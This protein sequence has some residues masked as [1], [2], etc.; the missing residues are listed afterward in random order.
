MAINPDDLLIFKKRA[1]IR[2]ETAAKV[3][4]TSNTQDSSELPVVIPTANSTSSVAAS[5]VVNPA[6]SNVIT[7]KKQRI[8]FFSRLRSKNINKEKEQKAEQKAKTSTK[9]VITTTTSLNAP[10]TSGNLTTPGNMQASTAAAGVN[11]TNA[12]ASKAQKNK[13]ENITKEEKKS[14]KKITTKKKDLER[15]ITKQINTESIA[16][17]FSKDKK[18]QELASTLLSENDIMTIK[19]S[20][21]DEPQNIPS[22]MNQE[23]TAKESVKGLS[24]INH[25]WRSAYAMCAYCHR[26]FCFADMTK[27]DNK[28]YCLEDIDQVTRTPAIKSKR[29]LGYNYIAGL[30]FLIGAVI[31]LYNSYPQI[32]YSVNYIISTIKGIGIVNFVKSI[33]LPY[34]YSLENTL[35]VAFSIIGGLLLFFRSNKAVIL[36]VL[37]LVIIT[38]V[39][40]YTYLESNVNYFLYAF[41]LYVLS[42]S[43]VALGKMTNIGSMSVSEVTEGIEWPK[44]ETF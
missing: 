6:P 22:K 13:K 38:L 23:K 7:P 10:I 19:T 35:L 18:K 41:V 39:V 9:K 24:C 37:L 43:I 33:S 29:I 15:H 40:S 34:L 44:I 16:F 4:S 1:D 27:R 3:Q 11:D 32:H 21:W 25:P 31:I 17:E 14:Q 12:V 36:S 28:N 30:I 26:P 2:T 42:I 20:G 5:T 8:S